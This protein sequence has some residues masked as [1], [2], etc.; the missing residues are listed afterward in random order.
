MQTRSKSGIVQP[1]QFPEFSSFHTQLA[2]ITEPD[3]PSHFRQAIGQPA[4]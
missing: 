3:T 2:T 1:K 4:W